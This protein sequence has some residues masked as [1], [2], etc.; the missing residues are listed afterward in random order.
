MTRNSST[1]ASLFAALAA[2]LLLL[3]PG[4]ALAD[5]CDDCKKKCRKQ[6]DDCKKAAPKG[7]CKGPAKPVCYLFKNFQCPLAK[8][9]CLSVGCGV[10][11]PC[12][13]GPPGGGGKASG[14]PHLTTLDGKRYDLQTVGEYVLARSKSADIE[15]QARFAPRGKSVSVVAMAA[16][17]TAGHVIVFERDKEVVVDEQSPEVKGNTIYI[18]DNVDIVV[19]SRN[20][21]L[22]YVGDN[23]VWVR[24]NKGSLSVTIEPA[25]STRGSWDG[26]F[27]DFDGKPD[28]DIKTRAGKVFESKITK[29]IL[30]GEFSDSWRLKQ[31]ESFLPYGK[32]E[33]TETFTD[34]SFPKAY[35]SLAG[36]ER[37]VF[38]K[39]REICVAK[40][41]R[42]GDPLRNCIYDVAVTQ[43]DEFAESYADSREVA[44]KSAITLSGAF[45]MLL[46][47]RAG[48]GEFVP[49]FWSGESGEFL[50]ASVLSTEGKRLTV[51]RKKGVNPL[52]LRMPAEVGN[53][54]I[55]L[56][57]GEQS[58]KQDIAV[59]EVKATLNVPESVG[60]AEEFE[61]SWTG[62]LGRGDYIS[63]VK[64]GETNAHRYLAYFWANRQKN[65]VFQAPA[66]P[67]KY[68]VWYVLQGG[69]KRAPIA[70]KAITVGIANASVAPP[71]TTEAG[72]FIEFA[73]TGPNGKGDFIDI[74]K[75]GHTKVH[76]HLTY[77][78]TQRSKANK[79]RLRV[80]PDVGAYQIRYIA[81]TSAG[82]AVIASAP[83]V[84][85]EVT[86]EV[87]APNAVA[88]GERFEV[89]WTG[90]RRSNDFVAVF[91]EGETKS[92]RHFHY[93][94]A[95]KSGKSLIQAP[96]EPGTYELVYVLQGGGS[97]R[98]LA[99]K[100]FEVKAP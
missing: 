77:A 67:G 70:K 99:R 71:A 61:V 32:G 96:D 68:E 11:G 42:H 26:L 79:T 54:V 93:R 39:A 62:P 44:S 56:K 9:H 31:E 53:Y 90:P 22:V 28:N 55:E 94:W 65:R 45:G 91:R 16:I 76:G 81:S 23:I 37:E 97:R 12:D 38:M 88:P 5:G 7:L 82:R 1:L 21:F 98:M 60:G 49:V 10:G 27:G 15:L 18:D 36:I 80:P 17:K 47:P 30:Y 66:V 4:S 20:R 25:P 69:G 3:A 87:K 84:V 33:S 72:S 14:D 57:Q 83:I 74:V 40:G 46:Q 78:W 41:V 29:E 89:S 24:V 34:K 85:T 63:L 2:L 59:T 35:L 19:H 51:T 92:S 58:N 13:G 95:H 86:A 52:M 50:Q 8:R 64:A 75:A 100:K 48:Q 73:W 43:S 6:Q